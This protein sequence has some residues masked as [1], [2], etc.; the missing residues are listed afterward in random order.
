MPWRSARRAGVSICKSNFACPLLDSASQSTFFFS[1]CKETASPVLQV[2]PDSKP[3]HRTCQQRP[4]SRP[5]GVGLIRAFPQQAPACKSRWPN[6]RLGLPPLQHLRPPPPLALLFPS[7]RS[8]LPLE[9]TETHDN[10]DATLRADPMPR[11]RSMSS[12]WKQQP[13]AVVDKILR[14]AEVSKVR[15][16]KSAHLEGGLARQCTP[17]PL[18]PL[19]C[20]RKEEKRKD[21]SAWPLQD[22]LRF[23]LTSPLP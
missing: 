17:F 5:G 1:A 13:D 8:L 16:C 22:C 6:H 4:L 2:F 18:L 3:V 20:M 10:R 9:T 14:R 23:W 11:P 15:S 21:R 12:P 19:E 7:P